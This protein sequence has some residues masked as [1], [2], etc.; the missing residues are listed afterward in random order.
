MNARWAIKAAH[1][2]RAEVQQAELDDVTQ[3]AG[4]PDHDVR[5][6]GLRVAHATDDGDYLQRM[7]EVHGADLKKA[8]VIMLQPFIADIQANEQTAA[9]NSAE[10]G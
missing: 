8:C 2:E 4:R 5:V 7:L 3:L 6:D 10:L 1:L 9:S